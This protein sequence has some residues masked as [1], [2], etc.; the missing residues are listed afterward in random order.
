MKKLRQMILWI[1]LWVIIST[2]LAGGSLAQ[3]PDHPD[4]NPTTEAGVEGGGGEAG[5]VSTT[6]MVH[7]YV[8][9]YSSGAAPQAGIP[10]I[11][12]GGGWQAETVTNSEGYY[13]FAGLGAGSAALDLRLPPGAQAA[14]P[15]WTVR[16]GNPQPIHTNLG[17]YWGEVTSLPVTFSAQIE[18]KDPATL[19]INVKNQSGGAATG[20]VIDLKL[21]STVTAVNAGASAGS[22]D[23]SGYRVWAELGD[24]P[25]GQSATVTVKLAF[26]A[27][28]AAVAWAALSYQEQLT[29]LRF[30][31]NLPAPTVTVSKTNVDAPVSAA[32]AAESVAAA[33]VAPAETAK[34]APAPAEN[35]DVAVATAAPA[36]QSQAVVVATSAPAQ[37][38]SDE[39][40]PTTGED[41]NKAPVNWPGIAFL[42]V[43]IIGLGA[44]GVSTLSKRQI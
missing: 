38:Q 40:V 4:A 15:H 11:L 23:T 28:E 32:S 21:P 12:D 17:F 25:T 31:I 37:S 29:P 13:R 33:T 14:A 5:P 41:V 2:L 35:K 44:A 19:L 18:T 9:D 36:Q 6:G 24:L 27:E 42:M 30:Q 34:N 16:T 10:V 8:L 1:G 20:V 3:R 7:G 43:F 22:A 39:L 26:A